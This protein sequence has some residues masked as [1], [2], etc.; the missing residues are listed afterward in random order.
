MQSKGPRVSCT[1][2]RCAH[3]LWTLGLI[4]V[5]SLLLAA[6]GR[7]ASLVL[8]VFLALLLVL[9]VLALALLLPVIRPCVAAPTPVLIIVIVIVIV[10][11]RRRR[12]AFKVVVLL[13]AL[14][15][16]LAR[17]RPDPEGYAPRNS[18]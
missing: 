13:V 15:F 10:I 18:A 8:F 1:G 11:R 17:L 16:I 5:P 4:G 9:F 6:L 12:R 3:R 7:R 2:S 14:Q